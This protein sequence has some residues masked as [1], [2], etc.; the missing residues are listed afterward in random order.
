MVKAVS[1]EGNTDNLSAA[2]LEQ[3]LVQ[4]IGLRSQSGDLLSA[5][6]ESITL[7]DAEIADFKEKIEA[8]K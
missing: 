2:E 7:A 5:I 1:V 3:I 6:E 4:A 8:L